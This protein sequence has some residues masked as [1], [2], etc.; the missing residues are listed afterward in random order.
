MTSSNY[1]ITYY[2]VLDEVPGPMA[3]EKFAGE[4]FSE[5]IAHMLVL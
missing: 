3:P 4:K 1:A 5:K 2:Q